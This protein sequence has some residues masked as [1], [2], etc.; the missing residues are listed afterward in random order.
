[1]ERRYLVATLAIVATFATFSRGF[2]SLQHISLLRGQHP[3][4]LSQWAAKVR[5]HLRPAYPEE[6]QLLAEMNL[7]TVTQGRL[8]EQAL[9]QSQAAAR[10]AR[11]TAMREAERAR[12][13]A[14]RMRQQIARQNI[15]SAPIAIDLKGLDNLDQRMQVRVAALAQRVAAANVKLQISGAKLEA[16]SI[17][18]PNSAG[19]QSPCRSRAEVR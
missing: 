12:S 13:D 7:P 17:Q 16:I 18:T 4:A 15:S 8:A 6:A 14:R 19:R 2:Q 10:C 9:Q 11:E 5:T 1:M 3:S